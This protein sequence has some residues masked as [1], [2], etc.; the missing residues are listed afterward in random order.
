MSIVHHYREVSIVRHS[1]EPPRSTSAFFQRPDNNLESV[2]QGQ[3]TRSCR[4][5][6]VDMW[7]SNQRRMKINFARRRVQSEAHSFK[8]KY[9]IVCSH[10][11]FLLYCVTHHLQAVLAQLTCQL[12]TVRIIDVDD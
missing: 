3:A 6:V 1:F 2:S 10:I 11:S 8:R 7:R 5:R 12:D 9:R 4:E